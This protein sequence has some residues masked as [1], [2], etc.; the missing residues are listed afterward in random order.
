MWTADAPLHVGAV[1][2]YHD[3]LLQLYEFMFKVSLF[4]PLDSIGL[5][6]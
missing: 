4:I 3:Y 1:N 2:L 5:W 6:W